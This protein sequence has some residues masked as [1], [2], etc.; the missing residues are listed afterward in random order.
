M[1]VNADFSSV[2]ACAHIYFYFFFLH[3]GLCNKEGLEN[4]GDITLM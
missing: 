4:R 2:R 3:L 1:N